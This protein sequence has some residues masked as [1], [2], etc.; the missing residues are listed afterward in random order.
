MCG[1]LGYFGGNQERFIEKTKLEDIAHRGPDFS[2]STS[3]DNC[4]LGHTRLSILDLSENGNQP[5]HSK[6]N[7]YFIIFNGEIYNHIE[8]RQKYLDKVDFVSTSDT[9]T[10][11][12]G[13]IEYGIDFISKLNGIFAFC[14]YDTLTNDYMVVRDHF[15][16]KPLYYHINEKELCFSS[17]LK[18]ILPFLDDK[19]IDLHTVKKHVNFLWSTGEST[20]LN[21]VKKLL[22]G[23]LITGNSKDHSKVKF[24]QYYTI[25]FNDSKIEK[26]LEEHYID[27]LEEK[28]INA[29]ERQMLSDVPIGFFLS[30]GLDS[31]LIVAIARKLYPDRKI[32]SYTIK[33]PEIVK[34]GFSDD[35]FY[36][37]K[38]AQH[39]NVDLS[40]VNADT[41]VLKF[42]DKIVYHLD[43]PQSDS[44]PIN[45]YN[46][47]SQARKDGIK[48][49]LGGTA[50]DDLFSG[51]RRHQALDLEKYF[52]VIPVGIRKVLKKGVSRLDKKK[53]FFR[54]LNKLLANI[55]KSK[56]ERMMG[57]FSWL[58][59]ETLNGLFLERNNSDV[60]KR[61]KELNNQIPD[62]T[63]DLN[64]MLFWELN[65]FLVDHNL[66]YTDKL[67]MAT[68]VEVRVPFLDKELVEFSTKIPV[69]LKL[70]GK[71]T[72]YILKKVAERYLPKEVIYRPKTGFGAPVREW[73]LNDMSFM[74]EDYLSKE[75][76]ERRGIFEYAKIE[77]LLDKNRKGVE[78]VSYSIWALLSI[79]S[80]MRQFYDK[81][82]KL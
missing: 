66:N 15:G 30:G 21:E 60:F 13:V 37:E 51:Y 73:I 28:L 1:I 14:F 18:A 58:A 33:S 56:N 8:L 38:V 82:M 75:I 35:L 2:S 24:Q 72:K 68:G 65:T 22:P 57:Y 17:E 9:E 55:D 67:S 25:P 74:I 78:D 54:R 5:M 39:L 26:K 70:K 64:R 31:S 4:F 27:E 71:E 63:S 19:S 42:F 50:G 41:D 11:L 12:Y 59:P 76:V 46:I 77:Q 6:D 80:W 47:C 62:S 53:P 44:A 81:E 69:E 3:L 40:I 34:E 52:E 23:H 36:A 45:V 48:V 32:K 16:V 79:E 29:V 43:E 61:F 7:R 20:M 49:L 10:I